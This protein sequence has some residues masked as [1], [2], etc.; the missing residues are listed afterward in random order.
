MARTATN[1]KCGDESHAWT[2]MKRRLFPRCRN[3]VLQQQ[4][5]SH[6][7]DRPGLLRGRDSL[8]C[9]VSAG[10]LGQ[11]RRVT[12]GDLAKIL[13]LLIK[14]LFSKSPASVQRGLQPMG[15]NTT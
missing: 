3:A 2:F 9:T 8:G 10:V 13:I 5:K 11:G 14:L 12:S 4:A 6:L 1:N 7:T 15:A